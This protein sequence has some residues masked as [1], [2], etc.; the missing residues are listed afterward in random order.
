MPMSIDE[1][2]VEALKFACS[3]SLNGAGRFAR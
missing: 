3:E 1:L 2:E